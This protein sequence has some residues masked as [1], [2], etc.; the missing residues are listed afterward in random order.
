LVHDEA[1]R[2]V[3]ERRIDALTPSRGS[4]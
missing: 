3:L 1:E 2:R 4:G